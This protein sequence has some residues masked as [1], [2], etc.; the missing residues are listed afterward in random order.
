MGKA[1]GKNIL[2]EGPVIIE[3]DKE[4]DNNNNNNPLIVEYANKHP[5]VISM[6]EETMNE[7]ADYQ[8]GGAG[9]QSDINKEMEDKHDNHDANG[10]PVNKPTQPDNTSDGGLEHN[11]RWL[12]R[13]QQPLSRLTWDKHHQGNIFGQYAHE[14]AEQ[15]VDEYMHSMIL[16]DQCK[17][18]KSYLSHV[19]EFII[20]QYSVKSWLRKVRAGKDREA[21]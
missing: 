10:V 16:E 21:M 14:D 12:H 13:H 9:H 4:S 11:V 8:G 6:E 1:H 2:D 17:A 20:T 3:M 7:G 15:E 19:F 18:V 5:D